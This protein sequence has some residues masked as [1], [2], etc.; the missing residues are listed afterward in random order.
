MIIDERERLVR[1][2]QALL[3]EMEKTGCLG[4]WDRLTEW[5]TELLERLARL[6]A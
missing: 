4:G 2:I 5:R 6:V 1:E 3:A